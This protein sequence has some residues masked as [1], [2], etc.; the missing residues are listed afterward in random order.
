MRGNMSTYDYGSPSNDE[1]VFE[2]LRR[3]IVE[4]EQDAQLRL[5]QSLGDIIREWL[6][7]HPRRETAYYLGNEEFYVATTFERFWQLA[8]DVQ[9]EFSTFDSMMPYLRLSLNGAILDMLR[10]SS[11]PKEVQ[12]P[13]PDFLRKQQMEDDTSCHG[14]WERLQK[15]LLNV[16]EQRLAYL[17]FH[18]GLKPREIIHHYS[19]E[20]RDV[21][22]INRLR[23]HIMGRLLSNEDIHPNSKADRFLSLCEKRA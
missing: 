10:T 21:C 11:R 12:L 1:N 5:Q 13:Q 23:L 2:A 19:Q 15:D 6:R 22:E 14:V 17:L 9:L 3:A 20:F 4:G 18:C 16:H 7:H 8:C